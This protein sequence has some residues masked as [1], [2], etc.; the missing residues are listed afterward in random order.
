MSAFRQRKPMGADRALIRLEELCARSERCEDELRKKLSGWMIPASDSERIMDSLRKRRF[1]DDSRFARA[2]VRDKYRFN[3][4]GRIKIRMALRTKRIDPDLIEEALE[5][6]DQAA[7]IEILRRLLKAKN[8]SIPEE[9]QGYDRRVR[10]F[11]FAA[12]RGFESTLISAA[13]PNL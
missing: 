9:I 13:L 6:I 2:F 11:R 5:E 4:W 8:R 7:Y 10:L 12:S 1:V 3:G